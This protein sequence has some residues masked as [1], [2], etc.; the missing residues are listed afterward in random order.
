MTPI[1]GAQSLPVGHDD[2]ITDV[3]I[4]QTTQGFLKTASRD[5]ILKVW[6]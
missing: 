1:G 2:I 4:F 6:K 3:T 5:G